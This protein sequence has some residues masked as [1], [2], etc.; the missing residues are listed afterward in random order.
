MTIETITID[1]DTHAVVPRRLTAENGAKAALMGEFFEERAGTK[2]EVSWTT[3]KEIWAKAIDVVAAAPRPEAGQS[4]PLSDS[5]LVNI[6][7]RAGLGH[8]SDLLYEKNKDG[9]EVDYPTVEARKLAAFLMRQPDCTPK[10]EPRP[11]PTAIPM[12]ERLPV[13][14]DADYSGLILAFTR[15]TKEWVLQAWTHVH[16]CPNAYTHWQPT[17]LQRP[18]EVKP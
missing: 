10:T 1:T 5:D 9:I 4:A 8:T 13:H 2:T 17:G 11:V 12:S 14:T 15:F 3:I 18:A 7:Y 16:N 6:I